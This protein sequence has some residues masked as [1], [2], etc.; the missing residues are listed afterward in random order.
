MEKTDFLIPPQDLSPVRLCTDGRQR[1][2]PRILSKASCGFL[3]VRGPQ[4]LPCVP[5][6][7]GAPARPLTRDRNL[8]QVPAAGSI[9]GLTG[10]PAGH[11]C[12]SPGHRG[13]HCI[14]LSHPHC[15]PGTGPA[16]GCWLSVHT[17]SR[18]SSRLG[19]PGVGGQ[20]PGSTPGG[21]TH[22]GLGHQP[23]APESILGKR[24]TPLPARPTWLTLGHLAWPLLMTHVMGQW[25]LCQQ[26]PSGKA[27]LLVVSQTQ[28][29]GPSHHDWPPN[30]QAWAPS[31]TC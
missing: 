29:G 9:A 12:P 31:P 27:H 1:K 23:Q 2:T 14:L 10:H 3:E 4:E 26:S 19:G 17:E 24:T 16:C 11:A 22:A 18:M 6:V 13:A 15:P 28:C 20:L 21:A 8:G 7:W 25:A 30:T 5:A